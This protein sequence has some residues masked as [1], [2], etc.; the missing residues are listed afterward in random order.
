MKDEKGNCVAGDHIIAIN[1]LYMKEKEVLKK[2]SVVTTFMVNK[3]F[4]IAMKKQGIHVFKTNV[5]DRHVVDEMIRNGCVLGGEQSGHII[6]FEYSTTG[7]GIVSA[8]QLMRIM[9]EKEQE[10]SILAQCMNAL[11]QII[12]NVEVK[13][14]S[15]IN[16][17]HV[18]KKIA[19]TEKILGETGRILVRYSGTQ[20]LCRIMIEGEDKNKIKKM[21]DDIAEAMKKEIGA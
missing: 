7:D 12:A 5:G 6:F 2:N 13:E 19:E 17:L 10:L 14:K 9:K 16:A 15:D 11:P 8:L 20:N 18:S 1:A 3:G 4:D 21:A